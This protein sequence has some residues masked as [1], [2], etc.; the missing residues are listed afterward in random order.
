MANWLATRSCPSDCLSNLVDVV[1]N[2]GWLR[3]NARLVD[4]TCRGDTVEIFA[5]DGYAHNEVHKS[6]SIGIDSILN[7]QDL[8]VDICLSR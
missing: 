1:D 2:V 8:V 6:R 7:C 4:D 3:T 5:T